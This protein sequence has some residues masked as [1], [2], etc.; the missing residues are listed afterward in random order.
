M[1]HP[2][3]LLFQPHKAVHCHLRGT[4]TILHRK[5]DVLFD[6][7][8]LAYECEICAP[9]WHH[10][11]AVTW[12]ASEE[13]RSDIRHQAGN[14]NGAVDRRVQWKAQMSKEFFKDLPAGALDQGLLDVIALCGGIEPVSPED[15]NV[16]WLVDEM[17]LVWDHDAH[18]P[19]AVLEGGESTRAGFIASE[20]SE[21]LEEEARWG[22]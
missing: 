18:A 22:M 12:Y 4:D 20:F 15:L 7:D 19:V 13:L 11:R 6:L 8:K 14:G 2:G 21:V 17:R 16:G 10:G 5:H 9:L 1:I 3:G